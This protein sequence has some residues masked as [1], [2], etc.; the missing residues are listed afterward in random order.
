MKM[1]D[2]LVFLY[3]GQPRM[4][5]SGLRYRDKA[6]QGIS[7][8]SISSIYALDSS[9][10]SEHS[11]KREPLKSNILNIC[12]DPHLHSVFKFSLISTSPCHRVL[13]QKLAALESLLRIRSSLSSRDV[14]LLLRTDLALPLSLHRLLL[15]A[16][17]GDRIMVPSYPYQTM[18]IN[19]ASFTPICDQIWIMP[20]TIVN[21]TAEF[22][23]FSLSMLN[24]LPESIYSQLSR[25]PEALV[26]Y[27]LSCFTGSDLNFV[28]TVFEPL[29]DRSSL[30]AYPHNL[31]RSDF[32]RW[33]KCAPIV[34]LGRT[35]RTASVRLREHLKFGRIPSR[36]V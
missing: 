27:A 10:F 5:S 25:S 36:G 28:P 22:L 16:A 29:F 21:E 3:T 14:I 30:E 34:R 33:V 12:S 6:L 20:G 15:A 17:Q 31:I 4:A 7:V 23:R 32:Y 2:S 1:V 26:P 35:A 19:G 24:S 8:D 9:L 13:G 11:V 18:Y